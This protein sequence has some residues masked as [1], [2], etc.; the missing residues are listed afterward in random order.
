MIKKAIFFIIGVYI[1]LTEIYLMI[2]YFPK[3]ISV[4][5]DN[6]IQFDTEIINFFIG[7][8]LNIVFSLIF[9]VICMGVLL[10]PFILLEKLQK[11]II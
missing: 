9:V 2:N 1:F 4:V 8:P 10:A 5:P 11:S 3:F 7:L 6:G